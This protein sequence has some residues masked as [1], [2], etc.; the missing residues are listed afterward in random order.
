M[1]LKT[2]NIEE[3][4]YKKFSAYCRKEGISMSRKIENFLRGEIEKIGFKGKIGR[5]IAKIVEKRALELK[6]EEHPLSKYC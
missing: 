4:I 6:P 1:A 5:N 2:F 3:E